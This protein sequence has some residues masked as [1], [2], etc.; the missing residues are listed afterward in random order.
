[1][2][3]Y[4]RALKHVDMKRVKKLHEQKLEENNNLKRLQEE[5]L[6]YLR[7][8]CSPEFSNWRCDLQEGPTMSSAG[9][10]TATLPGQ[11]DTDLVVTSLD[12]SSYSD[13]S[14]D[15]S[16]SGG[17][18]SGFTGGFSSSD[19]TINVGGESS[20][21]S[22][23]STNS[24]DF[25]AV[26]TVNITAIA[27]NNSNGGMLPTRSLNVYFMTVDDASDAIEVISTS[28]SSF[29]NVNITIPEKFRTSGVT[30]V[31]DTNTSDGHGYHGR[32]FRS[33]TIPISGLN[34]TT[35]SNLFPDSDDGFAAAANMISF[36]LRDNKNSQSDY[37]GL[38]EFIWFN[39]MLQRYGW[40]NNVGTDEDPELEYITWP[41]APISGATI[42]PDVTDAD[43]IHIGQTVYNLFKGTKLYG[44]SNISFR[45]RRPMNVLV[46]LDS[47]EATAFIR[48]SPTLSNL[49]PQERL[50]KLRK[51]LKAGDEYVAKML[52]VNFPGTGAVPPGEYDPFAQAP[53][54]EAGTT[55]GVDINDYSPN[56]PADY[57]NAADELLGNSEMT[58]DD[59]KSL[60]KAMRASGPE[61]AQLADAGVLS[62]PAAAAFLA[63]PAGQAAIAIGGAFLVKTLMDAVPQVQQMVGGTDWGAAPGRET[64]G[65]LPG[66]GG[67]A[68][69]RELTP[70]QQ[71]EVEAV[72]KELRDAQRALRD[73]EDNPNATDTQIDM[74]RER[75]DRANKKRRSTRSRHKQENQNRKESFEINGEVLTEKKKLK[76][77]SDIMNKIPGYYDG[78]PSPL[79]F[80]I[81][82]PPKM[83][84]GY[85][86]D[87]VVG[88]K[89]ANRFNRLDPISAKAMPM[90]GN[91]HIDKKVRAAR[92]K[93]K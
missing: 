56:E 76:S 86:P 75:L 53:P 13:D 87:L 79:G 64:V 47:P 54:G 44:I 40:F 78:K 55:P 88:K 62:V 68:G 21:S 11:G 42:E 46:S 28:A 6:E 43:Y 50:K 70:Q 85:H 92:K 34:H 61:V 14:G 23:F 58:P 57:L 9:M 48:D 33:Q 67:T 16:F 19:G 25:S 91:P 84:N 35:M 29:R 89:V 82:E 52:G 39:S 8:L 1:M 80:P 74:A 69:G 38:G 4:S 41:A 17:T 30:L 73:L 15:N 71:A 31:I 90:T 66:R 27:G 18:D 32:H 65:N 12:A 26:D 45:R 51:M 81:E 93:P 20:Y 22:G 63:S 60:E 72:G 7:N 2:S 37:R 5:R 83:K 77:P 59:V 49:S 10:F 36:Y 3:L 24:F